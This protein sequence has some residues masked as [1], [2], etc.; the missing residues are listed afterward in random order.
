MSVVESPGSCREGAA[1]IPTAYMAPPPERRTR[2]RSCCERL[3]EQV[4]ERTAA[5]GSGAEFLPG[6]L[7]EVGGGGKGHALKVQKDDEAH[8]RQAGGTGGGESCCRGR[9]W[10]PSQR[11]SLD[12]LT[13]GGFESPTLAYHPM[14]QTTRPSLPLAQFNIL[15]GHESVLGADMMGGCLL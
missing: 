14:V 11:A 10:R 7:W 2:R 3:T 1:S 15:V 8:L 6:S 5:G 9:W 13:T 4:A 12:V